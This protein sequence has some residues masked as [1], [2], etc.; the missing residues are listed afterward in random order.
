MDPTAPDVRI[1]TK[2][3]SSLEINKDF[4]KDLLVLLDEILEVGNGLTCFFFCKDFYM[5]YVM[6]IRLGES[7]GSMSG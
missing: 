7:V 4:S 6:L 2:A 3:L 1:Y 5:K